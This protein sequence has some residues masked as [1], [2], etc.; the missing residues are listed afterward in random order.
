[1]L[2]FM[3]PFSYQYPYLS[4][5]VLDQWTSQFGEQEWLSLLH[6]Q[7]TYEANVNYYFFVFLSKHLPRGL[8][9]CQGPPGQSYLY[10]I[11][12]KLTFY[13]LKIKEFGVTYE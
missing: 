6:K 13:D 12:L 8:D 2:M 3:L 9:W 10:E 5:L 1:M 7:K 4:T 11:S